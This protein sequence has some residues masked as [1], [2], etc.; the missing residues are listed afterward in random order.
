MNY[1]KAAIELWN[2]LDNI[3]TLS[4]AC[5]GNS[6]QYA[7]LVNKHVRKRHN[8]MGTDGYSLFSPDGDVVDYHSG[9]DTR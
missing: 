4:D 1:K 2:I 3:D 6:E 8:I 5:R 9:S 7:N